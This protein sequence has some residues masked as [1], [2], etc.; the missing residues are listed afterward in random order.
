MGDA[1]P[2][3]L[4]TQ[5]NQVNEAVEGP[6]NFV[7]YRDLNGT[8]GAPITDGMAA[9]LAERPDLLKHGF[10]VV[11]LG[12]QNV[13]AVDRN[14]NEPITND[15]VKGW[16]NELGRIEK[17]MAAEKLNSYGPAEEPAQ[18]GGTKQYTDPAG[19]SDHGPMELDPKQFP[20]I[21]PPK[22]D[23]PNKWDHGPMELDP[24]Q[25]A[26]IAPPNSGATKKW[27]HGTADLRVKSQSGSVYEDYRALKVQ[28]SLHSDPQASVLA[29]SLP[30]A[31]RK[32]PETRAA[33]IRTAPSKPFHGPSH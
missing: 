24:S 7:S 2:S 31:N 29:H 16:V 21:A 23:N 18:S 25:F 9:S 1:S 30:T 15:K 11:K 4:V 3:T 12:N 8:I 13:L 20:P 17:K 5:L 33:P 28:H 22:A 32:N 19:K 26:P 27:D 10:N 6:F 14:P